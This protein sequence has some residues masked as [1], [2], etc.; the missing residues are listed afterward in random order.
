VERNEDEPGRLD[1]VT[2]FGSIGDV[3][4]GFPIIS[5]AYLCHFNILPM[6]SE[7]IEPSRRRIKTVLH[8]TMTICSLLYLIVG[9][10]GTLT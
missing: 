8:S 4:Y 7:L 2:M 3:L 9:Y 1:H 10:L 5:I 6:N